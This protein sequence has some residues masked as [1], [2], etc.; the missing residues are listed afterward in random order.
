MSLFFRKENEIKVIGHDGLVTIKEIDEYEEEHVVTL[1][2]RQ[3][4]EIVNNCK[5]VF[6]EADKED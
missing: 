2:S 3:F 6:E 1:S 5:H 4:K